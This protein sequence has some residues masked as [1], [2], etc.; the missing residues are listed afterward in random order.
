M[1]KNP[2][3]LHLR[4]WRYIHLSATQS[5]KLQRKFNDCCI[6]AKVWKH[7]VKNMIIL[8]NVLTWIWWGIVI[9]AIID[10]LIPCLSNFL[11]SNDLFKGSMKC[12]NANPAD[13]LKI[14]CDA[15]KQNESELEKNNNSVFS[16]IVC[17][18]VR[19]ISH[20]NPH[21]N[22]TYGSRDI[23]MLVMLKTIKYKG[24]L[25]LLLA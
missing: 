13:I 7:G 5:K 25:M 12:K 14:K 3:K 16:F 10:P 9:N 8:T 11:G 21:Q 20:W 19:A 4:F 6:S 1:L 17:H 18:N 15:I 2:S 24:N 22:W 23:T